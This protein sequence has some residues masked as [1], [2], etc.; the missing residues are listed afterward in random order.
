MAWPRTS[1]TPGSIHQSMPYFIVH[2]GCFRRMCV[3][4]GA[5]FS[6]ASA[7]KGL[8]HACNSMPRACDSFTAN[9]SGSQN[10]SGARPICPVKKGD[11]GSSSDA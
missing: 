3:L 6:P 11:H 7:R 1:G 5:C 9:S 2:S 4:L 10:G 8:N